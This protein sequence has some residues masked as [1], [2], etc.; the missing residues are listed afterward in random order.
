MKSNLFVGVG[1]RAFGV[2]AI[3]AAAG[4][5]SAGLTLT[6]A[7]VARGFQLSTFVSG[8]PSV[9]GIGPV[10]IDFQLDGS[11]LVT[12]FVGND[13]RRFANVDNQTPADGTLLAYPGTEFC[14][15]VAHIGPTNYISHFTSQSIEE[16]NPD[17]SVNH[18][19][20][21]GIGNARA[22][23]VHPITSEL[24]VSTVQGIRG[25]NAISG[26]VRNI[27]DLHVDGLGVSADGSVVF[28]SVLG[29]GP[30]GHVLGVNTTTGAV[31]FDSGFIGFGGA[32]GVAVGYSALAGYL[33]VNCTDGR[34][35]EVN[36]NTLAQTLI[37]D[38]GS[39]GD[40]LA[41]DPSS[42]GDILL[43]QSDSVIRL[44]GIPTPAGATLALMAL[45]VAARRRRR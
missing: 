6:P 34:V 45:P 43:S 21:S 4:T 10:G 19:V 7:G 31:V 16:L 32:D 40:F 20:A 17:G 8:Y 18:V 42:N 28:G 38:G 13:I 27:S 12:G 30:G 9:G 37:A 5:A 44:T 41:S 29:N 3:L 11:V 15:D 22:L 39:R 1:L 25:V 2:A 26:A 36:M 35:W 33:Y 24:L 23:K 14:H